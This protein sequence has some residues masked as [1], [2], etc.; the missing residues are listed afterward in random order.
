MAMLG[1]VAALALTVVAQAPPAFAASPGITITCAGTSSNCTVSGAG[2][3]PG[4]RVQVQASAGGAVFSSSSLVASEPTRV[5]VQ[6]PRPYCFEYGGGTFTAALP[7]DYGLVCD[8]TAAG[9]VQYTDATGVAV[10]K[11]VTWVGPCPAPTT[12]TLSIPST[13]DT[14]WTL[15][16]PAGVTGD[17]TEGSNAVTSGTITITANGFPVCSYTPGA[18]SGCGAT[19]PAGTDRVQASYSGSTI[20]PWDPS[21]SAPV[22]VNVI[23]VQPSEAVS[24]Q[25]WAGYAATGETYT[26]V[27]ANWIVPT[28]N[29]GGAVA[30]VSSTWVGIDG[31]GNKPVEQIGTYS[32]CE[33]IIG[34]EYWAWWE[35][36]PD[37]S[38][39][40]GSALTN[41]YPVFAGDL[42]S[43]SVT[44]TGTP[45]SYTLTIEDQ[46]HD[47]IFS[48]TQSNPNAAGISAECVEERPDAFGLPLT[49]F[50]SVTFNNCEVTG[51]DGIARPI[52]D[53][54]NEAVGM[55]NGN[56]TQRAVVSPLS[57]DGTRFTATWLSG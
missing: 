17:L 5:C 15:V 16:N 35:M 27:S 7:V 18:S 12:T 40:I 24:S 2:F 32:N 30:T 13:V 26:A 56:T 33:P 23:Q 39:G 52:W 55:F 36:A 21:S 31:D 49:N 8:A 37:A 45:G 43:A 28:A 10:T 38:V 57:D 53:H 54:A 11:P 34:A 14:G 4:G 50:G 25:N 9:T 3:T 22:T 41:N 20:P 48:T 47:W 51:D 1:T 46:S 19:L 44:Y 29:C 6:T 42:M